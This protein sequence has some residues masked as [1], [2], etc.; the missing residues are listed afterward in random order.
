MI[1]AEHK[2]AGFQKGRNH[3]I[4]TVLPSPED[5]A[6]RE[7]D[8][9]VMSTPEG[10]AFVRTPEDRFAKAKDYPWQPKYAD[11]DGLRMAYV[12]AGPENA[13]PILLLHGQPTWS[14]LYRRMIPLLTAAGHRVIAPDLIGFG[15][16][17]KPIDQRFHT[18]DTQADSLA[19]FV[20]A[21]DLTD[22]TLLCQD[23]GSVLGLTVA[24]EDQ[25]RFARILLTNGALLSF[26]KNPFYIPEPVEL[27]SEAAGFMEHMAASGAFAEPFPVFFQEWINYTL[28]AEAWRPE[29]MIA[30]SNL[31]GGREN[32]EAEKAAFA[33]PF[34]SLIYMAGPRTFP[35][36]ICQLGTRTQKAWIAL[37][38]FEKPFLNV[39]GVRDRDFGSKELQQLHIDLIPGAKGQPHTSIDAGHFSQDNKGE[40][41]A[42]I[43]IRFIADNP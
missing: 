33:A 17:D 41:L 20:A 10:V 7:P 25:D 5:L 9:E 37:G 23:W 11:I 8:V 6:A 13:K 32:S 28:T 24:A 21:L 16:S 3:K 12:D 35:S 2:T 18:F 27:D 4:R 38:Q 29:D 26:V 40:E 30:L 31:V 19:T 43:L 22:T 1:K 34:P 36:M 14:Y 39:R 42:E 15:Q